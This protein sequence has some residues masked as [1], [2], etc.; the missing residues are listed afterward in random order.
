MAQFLRRL[1]DF[2]ADLIKTG[3]NRPTAE[4]LSTFKIVVKKHLEIKSCDLT[5]QV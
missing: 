3:M 1:G 5:P 4:F 2:N